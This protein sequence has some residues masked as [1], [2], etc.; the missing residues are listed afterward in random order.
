MAHPSGLTAHPVLQNKGT[1][2][3]P[4]LGCPISSTCTALHVSTHANVDSWKHITY[5]LSGT[6]NDDCSCYITSPSLH[7]LLYLYSGSE[8]NLPPNML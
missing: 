6:C 2:T 5:L 1:E 4:R 3:P 7:E 8:H